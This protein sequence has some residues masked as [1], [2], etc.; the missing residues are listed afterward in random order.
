M[1]QDFSKK[2]MLLLFVTFTFTIS[3]FAQGQFRVLLFSKTDGFHHE[4]INEGVVAI[5]KLAERHTFTVDWQENASVFN[6]K[7]GPLVVVTAAGTI[8]ATAR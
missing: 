3:A 6:D 5:K 8:A 4:S 7:P 1:K 2:L